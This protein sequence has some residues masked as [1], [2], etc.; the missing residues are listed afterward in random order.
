MHKALRTTEYDAETGS[1]R[2]VFEFLTKEALDEAN[3]E[4]QQLSKGQQ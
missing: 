1:H 3:A 4:W 2:M